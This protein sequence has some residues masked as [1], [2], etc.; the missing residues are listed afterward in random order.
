MYRAALEG[1]D[2]QQ[3]VQ[4]SLSDPAI[5]RALAKAGRIGMF[6]VGKAARG[7]AEGARS[8]A[9]DEGLTI[10]P[11]GY[12][13]GRLDQSRVLIAS[14]P[15]PD[16]SSVRAAEAALAFF[17][18]FG[19]GDLIL[20]LISGGTS[21]LLAKPRPGLTLAAKRAAIR[22]L[23]SSGSSIVE[24]NRLRS[25]LSAVKAGKLGR[26]TSARIVSLV[27]SD[28]PGDDPAVVGS[29][30]TVRGQRGDRTRVVASNRSGMRASA[31]EASRRGLV[32]RIFR[33]RL[34]GEAFDEG[35]RFGRAAT[36]LAPGHVLIAGGETTVTLSDRPGKGGRN[37]EF[38]LGA[39]AELDGRTNFAVL[40][41]GSDGVDGNSRAAGAFVD[42][43]TMERARSLGIDPGRAL[44]RHDTEPFFR[45]LGDLLVTGPT[46][47]NVGD[48]AFAMRSSK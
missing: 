34:R 30:P 41:A 12:P 21:S 13:R 15:L 1:V 36:R 3:A 42:G 17:A 10:L 35:R 20:C 27:L 25:R 16:R 7:M 26:G 32:P 45:R 6:A 14:H 22:R 11:R 39:A 43:A 48:W 38:A 19:P 8:I 4:R 44:A 33:R 2:P 29:G 47:T 46:G 9:W 23:A 37:L 24:L 18:G 5:G 31:A 28:V 40:A